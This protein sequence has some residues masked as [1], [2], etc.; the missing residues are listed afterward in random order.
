[1]GLEFKSK[2]S[3]EAAPPAIETRLFID[4][5]VRYHFAAKST[6]LIKRSFPVR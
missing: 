2:M 1:V 4:G 6:K 5:E 3:T